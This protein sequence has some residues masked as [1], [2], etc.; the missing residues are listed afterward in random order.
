MCDQEI[1]E[2]AINRKMGVSD[3]SSGSRAVTDLQNEGANASQSHSNST[4]TAGIEPC[5]EPCEGQNNT[6]GASLSPMGA[7]SASNSP[8]CIHNGHPSQFSPPQEAQRTPCRSRLSNR[9]ASRNI[10]SREIGSIPNNI[11]NSERV[12]PLPSAETENELHVS[13]NRVKVEILEALRDKKA[14]SSALIAVKEQK[15][16][17]NK[18]AQMLRQQNKALEAA[19]NL[20]SR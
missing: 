5:N 13:Y 9:R 17:L 14:Y 7:P 11:S 4:V 2:N 1:D 19:M 20:S 18:E 8:V 6:A 12:G 16:L 10:G 3:S 15:D